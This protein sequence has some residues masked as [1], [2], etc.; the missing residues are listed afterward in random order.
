MESLCSF[1]QH[2]LSFSTYSCSHF[3]DFLSDGQ[4]GKQG[5]MS[6]RGPK[7]TSNEGSPMAKARPCLMARD[8]RSEEISSQSLRS[9]VNPVNIDERKEVE[10]ATGNSMRSASRS[11]IR[12]LRECSNGSWKQRAGG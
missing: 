12:T 2:F 1:V 4:V 5:A 10:I 9:L 11:G 7:T 3:I 6:K 8:P